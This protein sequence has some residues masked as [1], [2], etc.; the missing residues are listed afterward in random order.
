MPALSSPHIISTKRKPSARV[1]AITSSMAKALHVGS[2]QFP[3]QKAALAFFREIRDRN[4]DGVRIGSDDDLALRDLLACHPEA[5]DK[6]GSGIA[7]FSIA[8]DGL[9]GTTRHFVV[10]RTD[11]SSTDFSFK[12]CIEGRNSNRDRMEALRRAV[13]DQIVAFRNRAFAGRPALVCPL[14]G[15]AVTLNNSHVDHGPPLGF[16]GLAGAWLSTEGLD[17]VELHISEPADN[18]I[19]TLLVDEAQRLSWQEFHRAN[20]T[21]RILSP[22]ANLSD[23][24]RR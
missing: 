8:T 11:G 4:S 22:R 18:Q 16:H 20:A 3:S 5:K 12:M 17:L 24:R 13:E 23:A 7:Y 15:I 6:I 9:F 10:F 1:A 14:S 21:L 2:R 19:V